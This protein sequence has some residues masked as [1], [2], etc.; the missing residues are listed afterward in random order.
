[1]T[2]I[3]VYYGVELSLDLGDVADMASSATMYVEGVSCVDGVEGI[4]WFTKEGVVESW[5]WLEYFLWEAGHSTAL[6]HFLSLSPSDLCP[7]IAVLFW[8]YIGGIS[9]FG[10]SVFGGVIDGVSGAGSI[11]VIDFSLPRPLHRV[12]RS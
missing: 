1:M 5:L 11:G 2:F 8:G 6:P 12:Y 10:S 7:F 9:G 3:G 4:L